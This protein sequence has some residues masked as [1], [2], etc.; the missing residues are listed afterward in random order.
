[1]KTFIYIFS[2]ALI[3]I[4]LLIFMSTFFSFFDGRSVVMYRILGL[5]IILG[6]AIRIFRYRKKKEIY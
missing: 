1:M 6:S 4:G 2:I 3:I 5:I